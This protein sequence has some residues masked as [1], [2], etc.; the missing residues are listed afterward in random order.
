M[1][2]EKFDITGMSCSACSSRVEKAVR[3]VD[4]TANVTVNLLTNSMQLE[5][6]EAKTN[7]AAI[8]AAVEHPRVRVVGKLLELGMDLQRDLLQFHRSV[9]RTGECADIC[10]YAVPARPADPLPQ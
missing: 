8:I 4:G 9:C 1:K 5:Y 6:D 3:K 10:V 2:K 7:P